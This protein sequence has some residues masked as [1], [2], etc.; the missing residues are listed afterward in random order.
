MWEFCKSGHKLNECIITKAYI[1]SPNSQC[2]M[3]PTFRD[4]SS[5][6][7]VHIPVIKVMEVTKAKVMTQQTPLLAV[8]CG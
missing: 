2:H 7:T 4:W 5:K 1:F 3:S 8:K 6:D